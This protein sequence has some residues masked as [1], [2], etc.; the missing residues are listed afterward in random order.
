MG[1]ESRARDLTRRCWLLWRRL[2]Y[3]AGR[4]RREARD[5]VLSSRPRDRKTIR[6]DVAQRFLRGDGTEIGAL[7][8][9]LRVPRRA[10]VRYVDYLDE[11]GLRESHSETP[12]EGRPLHG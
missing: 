10:R 12:R 2:R 9:P 11:P 7:D 8:F 1:D 4:G 5:I 3:V 6:E